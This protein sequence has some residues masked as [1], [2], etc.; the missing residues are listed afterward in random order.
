MQ[1]SGWSE[2][3]ERGLRLPNDRPLSQRFEREAEALIRGL[4]DWAVVLDLGGGL[5]ASMPA[6]SIP[7]AA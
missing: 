5:A 7:P 6:R 4:P 1:M 2:A 3:T